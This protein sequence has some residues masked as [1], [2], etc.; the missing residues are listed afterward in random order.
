MQLRETDNAG[1]GEINRIYCNITDCT[2]YI[3]IANDTCRAVMGSN[4]TSGFF[5]NVELKEHIIVLEL[6]AVLFELKSLARNI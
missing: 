1:V 4:S 2:S 3:K 5:Q 6:K